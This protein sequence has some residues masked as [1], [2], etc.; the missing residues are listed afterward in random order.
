MANK[1]DYTQDDGF[2]A[3]VE[4]MSYPKGMLA[5][6]FVTHEV[7]DEEFGEVQKVRASEDVPPH[8]AQFLD[9]GTRKAMDLTPLAELRALGHL[10]GKVPTTIDEFA[11]VV[12]VSSRTVYNWKKTEQFQEELSYYR[13]IK[14]GSDINQVAMKSLHVAKEEGVKAQKEREM[15]LKTAGIIDDSKEVRVTGEVRH[16]VED[17][18]RADIA[19]LRRKAMKELR[20]D[21]KFKNLTDKQLEAIRDNMISLMTGADFD[22][23]R[24]LTPSELTEQGGKDFLL[25]GMDP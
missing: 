14:I 17:V 5:S 8:L 10:D 23:D 25:G 12:G 7:V 4:W 20:N 24:L 21:P 19:D 6:C 11:A 3:F 15:W 13:G 16:T 22:D 1:K 2:M 18:R 9:D